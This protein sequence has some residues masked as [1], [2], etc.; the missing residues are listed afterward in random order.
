MFGADQLVYP[1]ELSLGTGCG[2][3]LVLLD[4]VHFSYPVNLCGIKMLVREATFLPSAIYN[5]LGKADLYL[6][7]NMVQVFLP[8]GGHMTV[9][10]VF[11]C[12]SEDCYVKE[13]EPLSR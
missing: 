1:D 13:I 8:R 6:D 7:Y 10:V 2:P 3:S 5:I 12:P 11:I 4:E 9:F